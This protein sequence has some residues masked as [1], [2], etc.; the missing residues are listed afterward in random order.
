MGLIG[1]LCRL[2]KQCLS[3]N[4]WREQEQR[5]SNPGQLVEKLELFLCPMP[6]PP[7]RFFSHYTFLLMFSSCLKRWRWTWCGSSFL[8]FDSFIIK[9]WIKCDFVFPKWFSKV[10]SQQSQFAKIDNKS[11]NENSWEEKWGRSWIKLLKMVS[12][13]EKVAPLRS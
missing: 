4:L 5:E 3:T 12:W 11:Q 13:E 1:S 7:L 6:P 9:I 10:V 2:T 8:F